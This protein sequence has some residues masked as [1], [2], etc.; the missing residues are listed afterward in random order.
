MA[1]QFGYFVGT[2]KMLINLVDR[3][4]IIKKISFEFLIVN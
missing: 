2:K 3:S 1:A 4:G